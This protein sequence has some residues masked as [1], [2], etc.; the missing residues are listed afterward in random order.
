MDEWTYFFGA[1]CSIR[2]HPKNEIKNLEEE[3]KWCGK[4]ADRMEEEAKKRKN[5]WPSQQL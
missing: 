5:R 2:F 1:I 4:V 3:I